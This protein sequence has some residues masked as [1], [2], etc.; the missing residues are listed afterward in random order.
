MKFRHLV[1]MGGVLFLVYK[2][3]ELSGRLDWAKLFANGEDED[4]NDI[5]TITISKPTK[6]KTMKGS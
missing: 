4:G 6:K 5:F 3:G 2:A 1:L